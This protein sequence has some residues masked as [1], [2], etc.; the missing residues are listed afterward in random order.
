M[1]RW[2]DH[3]I[4]TTLIAVLVTACAGPTTALP[5]TVPERPSSTTTAVPATASPRAV[6]PTVTPMPTNKP[7]PTQE[8]A[9]ESGSPAGWG[10]AQTREILA[11]GLRFDLPESFQGLPSDLDGQMAYRSPDLPDVQV[12]VMW[13]DLEP[14]ME[15]EAA[16][17]PTPS[18]VLASDPIDTAWGSGRVITLELLGMADEGHEAPVVGVAR[19]VLLVRTDV[20]GR[21]AVDFYLRAPGEKQLEAYAGLLDGMLESATFDED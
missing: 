19:H 13:R 6:P 16:L 21:R 20:P 8:L 15:P 11:L 12:G 7:E 5:T 18:R 3:L 4:L 1:A 2:T 17:L 14:P 10:P 9:T